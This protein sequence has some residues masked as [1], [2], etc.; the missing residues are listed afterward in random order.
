MNAEREK[1]LILIVEDDEA[2]GEVI[3]LTIEQETP[4][5]SQLVTNGKDALRFLLQSAIRPALLILDYRLPDVTGTEL[6]DRLEQAPGMKSV[7]ILLMSAT[8]RKEEIETRA[9]A[10]M[11]KPFELDEF[12]NT[13]QKLV[14]SSLPVEPLPS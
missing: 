14:T 11:E 8:N 6:L 1:P 4:Y 12:L 7:P 3:T 2:T 10:M 9:V 13:V 5:R